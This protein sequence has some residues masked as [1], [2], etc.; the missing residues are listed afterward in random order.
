MKTTLGR[1]TKNPFPKAI[2]GNGDSVWMILGF[3]DDPERHYRGVCI[4]PGNS[5]QDK[6]GQYSTR[7]LRSFDNGKK[8]P[9]KC[10][11]IAC[12]AGIGC[13]AY[14]PI[15]L[16]I[17]NTEPTTLAPV[18]IAPNGCIVLRNPKAPATGI[19]LFAAKDNCK[20]RD[21][22]VVCSSTS[23]PNMRAAVASCHEIHVTQEA[24]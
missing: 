13:L 7:I 14:K 21:G 11:R 17:E 8:H 19:P 9:P 15:G 5:A 4:F 6:L 1:Q 10:V 3:G 18:L 22:G 2:V 16:S 24:Q 20:F 23:C 12:T